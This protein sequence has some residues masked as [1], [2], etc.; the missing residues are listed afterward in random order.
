MINFQNQIE[1]EYENERQPIGVCEMIWRQT[2][3]MKK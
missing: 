2:E 3:M 1:R